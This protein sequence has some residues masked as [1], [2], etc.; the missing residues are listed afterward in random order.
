MRLPGFYWVRCGEKFTIAE[1]RGNNE[2]W[3]IGSEYDTD[4]K[5]FDE[6]YERVFTKTGAI[7]P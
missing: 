6:I 5:E 2:W 7:H 1:F 3:I 4:E